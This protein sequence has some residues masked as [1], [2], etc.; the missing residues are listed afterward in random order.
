MQLWNDYFNNNCTLTGFDIEPS[1]KKF[2]GIYK[3]ILIKI[4]DQ[5]NINDLFQLTDKQYDIIIDDG[6]H[7][8][9]HQQISFK[10]LWNNVKKGG[11]Y[12]IEDLHYQPINENCIKTRDL[13]KNILSVKN[14][15]T[16]YINKNEISAIISEID[17]IEF[18][19]SMSSQWGNSVK[20]ALVVIKKCF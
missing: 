20:D 3:N 2:N 7:A 14:Y 5:S 17:T 8:S 12:I 19:D 6:Y 11:Y 4:G 18:Y 16:E 9:M 1:F 13:F 10:T 15:N